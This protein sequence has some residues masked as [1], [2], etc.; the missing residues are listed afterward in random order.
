MKAF[1]IDLI[2]KIRKFSRT[3][4]DLTILT[5]HQWVLLNEVPNSKTVYIFRQQK[6]LLISE[7]GIVTKGSWEYLGHNSLL[8][9]TNS[10]TLLLKHAFADEHII[11]MK[12]DG[13]EDYIFLVN[14]TKFSQQMNSVADIVKFL[15]KK[16]LEKDIFSN[17][18]PATKNGVPTYTESSPL[19]SFD[20]VYGRHDKIYVYFADGIKGKMLKGY[21]TNK[22]FFNHARLGK[23]YCDS[24]FDCITELYNY[25]KFE[26]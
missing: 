11:A 22:Y 9:E 2:P 24:K 13:K 8:F 26:N 23:K 3:L 1:A 16:Y 17:P 7:N 12:I 5:T 20:L 21:S 18:V 4:E 15:E 19:K 25:N 14:E 10:Q 6:K